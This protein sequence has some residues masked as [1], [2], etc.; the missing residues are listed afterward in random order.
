ILERYRPARE[1]VAEAQT[2][3][4][5]IREVLDTTPLP[6]ATAAGPG[7]DAL[8]RE[9]A[10]VL[11]SLAERTE[12]SPWLC[13]VREHLWGVSERYWRGLF[14][15]YDLVGVPRTN[16]DLEGLFGATRRHIR[17]QS[18]AKQVRRAKGR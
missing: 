7:G 11:G 9:M 8:A 6:T 13:S 5:A 10:H 4:L 18:G 3:L 15:C 1:E 17:Q 2:W 16:N 12:L 14:V